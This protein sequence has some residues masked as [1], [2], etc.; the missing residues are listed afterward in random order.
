ME[1][2][3]ETAVSREEICLR[4]ASYNI[5]HGGD[6]LGDMTVLAEDILRVGA[7]IVGIQEVDM[8]TER[9]GGI[10]TLTPLA[11]AAGFPHYRFCKAIDY[12]GG[13]YGTAVM[14]R[15]PIEN[16]SVHSLPNYEGA[17]A[18]T[19]GHAVLSV[20]GVRVDFLNTHLTVVD[21]A[22]RLEQLRAV[23]ELLKGR[24]RWILTGDFNTTELSV[25][26]VIGDALI[27]NRG[28]YPT[29]FERMAGIDNILCPSNFTLVDSGM[30]PEEGH[31]D[32]NLLWAELACRED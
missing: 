31:S 12:R 19:V 27:V 17:E 23:A 3:R 26:D 21:D 20:D 14:S 6:V 32:H 10:N 11:E 22:L 4:V 1:N 25:F 29:F 5:R 2:L 18:R 28:E 16:F 13:E 9:V 30:L 7:Q 8:W 24:E 15:Y